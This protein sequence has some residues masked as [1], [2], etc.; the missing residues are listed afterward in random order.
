M[1]RC[2]CVRVCALPRCLRVPQAMRLKRASSPPKGFKPRVGELVEVQVIEAEED[3]PFYRLAEIRREREGLFFVRFGGPRGT[4]HDSVDR[5]RIRPSF[6]LQPAVG[7]YA[8]REIPMPGQ[9]IE[10]DFEAICDKSGALAMH[11]YPERPSVVA[12]GT[13][14]AVEL[15]QMLVELSIQK[16]SE[17]QQL[18]RAAAELKASQP[19]FACAF[20]AEFTVPLHMIGLVIGP[21]GEQIA[22]AKRECRG[23]VDVEVSKTTGT[24]AIHGDDEGG[25]GAARAMLEFQEDRAHTPLLPSDAA[26]AS[27]RLLVSHSFCFSSPRAPADVGRLCPLQ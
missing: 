16:H 8:K 15:A 18:R 11:E 9:D 6:G 20:H 27:M 2:A 19:K 23:L 7:D 5:R 12:L 4:R 14:K 3:E 25:V 10:L 13:T 22:K 26:A 1:T 24:V 21:K 17:R